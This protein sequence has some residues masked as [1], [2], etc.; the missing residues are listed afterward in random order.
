MEGN[1]GLGSDFPSLDGVPLTSDSSVKN[2]SVI[3]APA[4]SMEAQN[5]NV[6]RHAFLQLLHAWQLDSYLLCSDLATVSHT[7]VT[8]RLD[9]CNT[10]CVGLPL[11]LTRKFQLF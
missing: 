3:L 5:M 10:L 4:L 9:Y 6:A 8:F 11:R 7:M 1:T 2:L